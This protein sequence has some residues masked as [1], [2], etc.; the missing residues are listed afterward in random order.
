MN[1]SYIYLKPNLSHL[2]LKYLMNFQLIIPQISNVSSGREP[3]IR[4]CNHP[5]MM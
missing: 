4:N 1:T 2:Q 5:T 3:V